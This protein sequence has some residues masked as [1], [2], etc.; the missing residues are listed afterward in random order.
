MHPPS[1]KNLI[2]WSRRRVRTRIHHWRKDILDKAKKTSLENQLHQQ[3]MFDRWE[4]MTFAER[5]EYL[6]Q[7]YSEDWLPCL[8]HHGLVPEDPRIMEEEK[9]LKNAIVKHLQPRSA[10]NAC[11]AKIT[12][13]G[14]KE[15]DEARCENKVHIR[16]LREILHKYCPRYLFLETHGL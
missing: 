1:K 13:T 3:A 16:F 6:D 8:K 11:N 10:S 14:G 2:E 4:E 7:E 9:K 15:E 12:V 5:D